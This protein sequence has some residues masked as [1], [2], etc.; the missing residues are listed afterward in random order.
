MRAHSI[1][2]GRRDTGMVQFHGN[3]KTEGSPIDGESRRE[4]SSS[5]NGRSGLLR[6]LGTIVARSRP[7]LAGKRKASVGSSHGCNEAQSTRGHRRS[8]GW[9]ALNEAWLG[10]GVEK[11]EKM[12]ATSDKKM[13]QRFSGAGK[14]KWSGTLSAAGKGKNELWT[15]TRKDDM[16]ETKGE[17]RSDMRGEEKW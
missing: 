11:V 16:P 3:R 7:E 9:D 6:W 5:L 17:M 10:L 4:L 12:Y 14:R 15:P 2:P 13:P 1:L 8:Q